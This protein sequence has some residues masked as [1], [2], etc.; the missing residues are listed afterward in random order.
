MALIRCQD[1]YEATVRLVL[2]LI[3]SRVLNVYIK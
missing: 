3:M 2:V 1:G